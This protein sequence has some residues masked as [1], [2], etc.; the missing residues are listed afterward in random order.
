MSHGYIGHIITSENITI[1]FCHVGT[2]ADSWQTQADCVELVTLPDFANILC[3]KDLDTF[4]VS[5][6]S[7]KLEPACPNLKVRI[8]DSVGVFGL[9]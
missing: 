5:V 6:Q 2:G 1:L 3:P 4:C 9:T 8:V 7:A